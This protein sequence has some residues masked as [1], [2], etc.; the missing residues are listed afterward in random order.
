MIFYTDKNFIGIAMSDKQE[1][2]LDW[3]NVY[4][5]WLTSKVTLLTP[6]SL[7]GN[8]DWEYSETWISL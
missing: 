5:Q 7:L 6:I 4:L 8:K 2:S 3:L 1:S